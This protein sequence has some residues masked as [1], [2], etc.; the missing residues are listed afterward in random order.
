MADEQIEGMRHASVWPVFEALAPTLA[1]DH[2]AI[3]DEEAG[4]PT[5]RA[6]MVTVPTLVMNGTASYPFKVD[7]ARALA[8]RS[9][10]RRSTPWKVKPTT[11]SQ[12]S[13]LPCWRSSSLNDGVQSHQF[14]PP[15][16]DLHD[17]LLEENKMSA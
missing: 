10:M 16:P 7:I 12:R 4:V 8:K 13:S 1:Y 9:C 17:D 6:A 11:S 14:V 2:T 15:T 3:L 5:E